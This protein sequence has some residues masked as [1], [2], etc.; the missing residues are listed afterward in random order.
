M[1]KARGQHCLKVR[2]MQ[3]YGKDNPGAELLKIPLEGLHAIALQQIGEQESYIEELEDKIRSLEEDLAR[4]L[5]KE[6]LTKEENK[7]I[8]QE[9]RR[10]EVIAVVE[11]RSAKMKAEN[12]KLLQRNRELSGI[13]CQKSSEIYILKERLRKYED[14]D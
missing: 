4:K 14:V 8:A 13:I 6:Q 1:N 7:R 9:V 10:E 5:K 2:V 12:K 11:R 3:K